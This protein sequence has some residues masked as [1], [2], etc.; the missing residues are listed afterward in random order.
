MEDDF[1]I[2]CI[3][4][5]IES[6]NFDFKRDIYDFDIEKSKECLLQIVMQ[7]EVNIL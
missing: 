3:E 4:N 7:M 2:E 1:L 6:S 5:E